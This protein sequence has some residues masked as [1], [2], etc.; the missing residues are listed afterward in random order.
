VVSLKKAPR[1][2]RR[3]TTWKKKDAREPGQKKGGGEFC[4]TVTIQEGTTEK[5]EKTEYMEAE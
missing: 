1:G 4:Q 5:R 2:V 3:T